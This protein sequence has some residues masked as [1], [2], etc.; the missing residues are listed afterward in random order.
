MPRSDCAV[1]SHFRSGLPRLVGENPVCT[2][3][4]K[5]ELVGARVISDWYSPISWLPVVPALKRRF[6]FEMLLAC[7]RKSSSFTFHEKPADGKYPHLFFAPN[8]DEPSALPVTV[9]LYL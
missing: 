2:V 4:F 8:L 5:K 9:K 7:L 6:K 1:F 3:P